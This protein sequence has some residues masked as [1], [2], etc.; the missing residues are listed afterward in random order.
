MSALKAFA[1]AGAL[2]WSGAGAA[3]EGHPVYPIDDG[4]GSMI[5]VL[6]SVEDNFLSNADLFLQFGKK[7]DRPYGHVAYCEVSK[8]C[9]HRSLTGSIVSEEMI[10]Y[11]TT[12][13]VIANRSITGVKDIS[14]FGKEEFWGK[15]VTF[16]G[17]MYGDCDDYV[18]YKI[19]MLES[20][21]IPRS[22]MSIA[23]VITQSGEGHAVL[24]VRFETGDLVLDNL[25]DELLSPSDSP[26][27]FIKA[28]AWTDDSQWQV[29]AK[30][31]KPVNTADL[32]L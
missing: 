2:M 18:L 3:D 19:D 7:T 1:V 26:H 28:T 22:A 32:G 12:F 23:A 14:L 5:P 27:H 24:L 16:F 31:L 8:E 11:I 17:R 20:M 15:P 10:P 9:N 30:G 4:Y 21:G 13:N 29:V 6:A 25:T